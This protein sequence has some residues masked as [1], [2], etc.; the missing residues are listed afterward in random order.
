M[1]KSSFFSL[2]LK[3]L[4]ISCFDNRLCFT[5]YASGEYCF[6]LHSTVASEDAVKAVAGGQA[7]SGGVQN[8]SIKPKE[9][10]D[11]GEAAFEGSPW[12]NLKFNGGDKITSVKLG[13]EGAGLSIFYNLQVYNGVP[14]TIDSRGADFLTFVVDFSGLSIDSSNFFYLPSVLVGISAPKQI[15]LS[16]LLQFSFVAASYRSKTNSVTTISR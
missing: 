7:Y 8:Y 9:R 15:F 12:E 11:A 1:S 16:S 14:I 6:K 13:Q 2:S 10:I 5:T 4:L 3:S